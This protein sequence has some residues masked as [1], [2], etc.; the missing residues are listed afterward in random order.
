[1]ISTTAKILGKNVRD[2][3]VMILDR[4]RNQ[5]LIDEVRR[6][7]A[8]LRMIVDGDISAALAPALSESIID[9]Y[10]GIGGA[11]KACW[12]PR[13]FVAWAGACRPKSGRA[14]PPNANR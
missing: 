1:M 14:T 11:P 7:G 5:H 4:P 13:H 12:P 8:S 6:V 10:A 9:L 2:V 3:T